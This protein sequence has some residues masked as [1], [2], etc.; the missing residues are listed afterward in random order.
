MRAAH[1]VAD[2]RETEWRLRLPA[3]GVEA[4]I[5]GDR[6]V[7]LEVAPVK[8]RGKIRTALHVTHRVDVNGALSRAARLREL[9][10]HVPR[11]L[12]QV[13]VRV[14]DDAPAAPLVVEQARNHVV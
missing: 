4:G 14:G 13:R 7:S 5:A 6:L 3:T 12:L 10:S 9:T 2:A 8:V 1:H 11:D